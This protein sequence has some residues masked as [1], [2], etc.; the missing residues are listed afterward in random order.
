MDNKQSA[1]RDSLPIAYCQLALAV[2]GLVQRTVGSPG[3]GVRS[4]TLRLKR[5]SD[6]G[7]PTPD[8]RLVFVSF[9]W[10]KQLF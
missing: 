6:F 4:K 1:T 3:S 2:C 9:L 5:H 10:Y 8:S 7:L